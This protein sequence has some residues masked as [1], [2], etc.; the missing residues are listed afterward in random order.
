MIHSE[1]GFSAFELKFGSVDKKFMILPDDD[2][3]SNN[4]PEMLQLLNDDIKCIRDISYKWQQD[5]IRK[6]DNSAHTLNKYQPGDFVLFE[7]SVDN[8]RLHKLDA[9]FLG[10]YVVTSHIH[11]E[12]SVRNLIS[13]AVSIFHCTRVKPFIGSPTEAK[14]A[15]LRDADQYYI[16]RF[17]AYK[18]DPEVRSSMIFYIRFADTCCHW[19]PW[20]KDLYDTL[21]YEEY[22]NSLP[23]LRPLVVMHKEYLTLKKIT[24]QTPI[25]GVEPGTFVYMDLRALGAG[26]Y[27]FLNLPDPDFSTYVVPLEYISWQNASHTK[28]NCIIPSLGLR[29]SGRNAVS[30]SFVKWWGS[31]REVSDKMTVITNHFISEHNIIDILKENN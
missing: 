25:E 12:V 31:L 26:L 7:Y 13:D 15:A 5:L 27:D 24:N 18:G 6:R 14:E 23:E 30:H 17:L 11:N 10:P 20:S 19:K 28:I 8:T 3:L 2:L 1:T 9:K 22:C 21:Q 16:D 29:W 4:A